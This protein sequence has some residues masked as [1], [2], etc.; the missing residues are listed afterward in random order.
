MQLPK[1]VGILHV[2]GMVLE[3]MYGFIIGK[4]IM[5]DKLYMISFVSI[6]LSWV[7]FQ[8]ECVISYIM[9]KME[10]R[11][12]ILGSEP[13]NAKD[14]TDLFANKR[15]YLIFY[16]V[17]NVLRIF[18]VIVVNA[19][20]T[21]IPHTVLIPTFVLFL[22]YNYDITYNLGFRKRLYPYFHILLCAYLFATFLHTCMIP[23]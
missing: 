22:G 23:I 20:T 8:D 21:H 18:S 9:K 15:Q 13:E 17:N 3:N 7:L 4:N 1:C 2:C 12:Y 11:N 5:F 6:P 19:R 16:H 14:I 10:N